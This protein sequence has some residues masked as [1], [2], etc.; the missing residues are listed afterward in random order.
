MKAF[1]ECETCGFLHPAPIVTVEPHPE[2]SGICFFISNDRLQ[3][4]QRDPNYLTFTCPV[5]HSV[6]GFQADDY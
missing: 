4:D 1:L 6:E 3:S 5:C 2:E